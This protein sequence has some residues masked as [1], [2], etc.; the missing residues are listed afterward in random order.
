MYL[1][2]QRWISNDYFSILC[3]LQLSVPDNELKDC[4]DLRNFKNV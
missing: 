2:V 4:L 3:Q 1:N